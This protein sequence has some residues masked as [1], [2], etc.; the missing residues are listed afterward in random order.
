MSAES[1][2]CHAETGLTPLCHG[3][4]TECQPADGR[5]EQDG[6]KLNGNYT[7]HLTSTMF[8]WLT[9]YNTRAKVLSRDF[10]APSALAV[11]PQNKA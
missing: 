10:A 4:E 8:I 6:I 2:P 5:S 7:C 1:L 3:A 11:H 9:R